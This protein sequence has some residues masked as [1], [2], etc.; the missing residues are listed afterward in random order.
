MIGNTCTLTTL[1]GP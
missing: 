1:N